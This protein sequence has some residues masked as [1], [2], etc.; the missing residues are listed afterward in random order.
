MTV[1]YYLELAEQ[2]DLLHEFE[3][4]R[5]VA[6]EQVDPVSH[7]RRLLVTYCTAG[8]AANDTWW[9]TLPAIAARLVGTPDAVMVR[10]DRTAGPPP[11]PWL[12]HTTYLRRTGEP[13]TA[14]P[15]RSEAVTVRPAVPQD[16][17]SLRRWIGQ[18][19]SNAA[20]AQGHAAEHDDIQET[21]AGLLSHP[22][23]R[24]FAADHGAAT[25]GHAT[26][27]CEERDEIT[28]EAYIELFDLLVEAAAEVRSA[29]TDALTRACL[30][31]AAEAGLPLIGNVTHPL[32]PGADGK[33]QRIVGAL[34]AQGWSQD[35]TLWYRTCPGKAS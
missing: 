9:A 20:T 29:A 8:L 3:G 23:R 10:L 35:H 2:A 1:A 21:A 18:A 24:S 6:G 4:G 34:I 19:L 31:W 7:E 32:T 26:L 28:G 14:P 33:A 17:V 5:F 13:A 15:P 12:R 22:G 11:S 16:E 27:L 25:V 30:R